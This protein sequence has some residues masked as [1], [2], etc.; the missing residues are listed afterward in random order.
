MPIEE[1]LLIA[2]FV[3]G[4]RSANAA[5]PPSVLS[6]S[7]IARS[8]PTTRY[9]FSQASTTAEKASEMELSCRHTELGAV[10]T[11]YLLCLRLKVTTTG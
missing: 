6:Q 4:F 8:F 7:G 9:T 3:V 2:P 5:P 1:E 11:E 10:A